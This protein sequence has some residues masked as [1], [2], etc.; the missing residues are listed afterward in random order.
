M[1]NL[2]LISLTAFLLGVAIGLH[3]AETK[4]R[5]IFKKHRKQLE[6]LTLM[7]MMLTKGQS[8]ENG[9]GGYERDKDGNI[10]SPL[11]QGRPGS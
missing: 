6:E 8:A 1:L 10:L 5:A 4:Y 7:A 2:I 11:Q 9:E 3:T